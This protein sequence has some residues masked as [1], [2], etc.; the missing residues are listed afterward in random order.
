MPNTAAIPHNPYLRNDLYE[1]S[2]RLNA[3]NKKRG[4]DL[5]GQIEKYL[6]GIIQELEERSPVGKTGDFRSGWAD[7]SGIRHISKSRSVITIANNPQLKYSYFLE[8]GSEFGEKPW[9]GV[10]K[11]GNTVAVSKSGKTRLAEDPYTGELRVWAG[12]LNPGGSASIGGV[13]R[14]VLGRNYQEEAERIIEGYLRHIRAC[15][16][17]EK[18]GFTLSGIPLKDLE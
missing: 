15:L 9:P 7:F 14:Q 13:A 11:D 6:K 12:G 2:R 10:D 17:A 18:T 8:Y 5:R 1:Y 4:R 3:T 16:A